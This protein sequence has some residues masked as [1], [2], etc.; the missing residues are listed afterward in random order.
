MPAR[1]ASIGA[2]A[3]LGLAV[4]TAGAAHASNG[5]A[6]ANEGAT[7]THKGATAAHRLTHACRAAAGPAG[8]QLVTETFTGATAPEFT[9]YNEACLTG[10]PEGAPPHG[11]HGL[12]GCEHS[13][14]GPVPPL[15]AAPHGYLR[16]TDAGND[17][18]AAVLYNHALPS[19]AGFDVTFDAWQYGSTTPIA[20]AD[21]ISFFL[22]DGEASLTVPGQFGGSLG[23]AQKQSHLPG[24]GVTPIEPGVNDGYLGVGLDALGNYFADNEQRGNGCA[25][26]SPAGPALASNVSYKERGPNMVI[27]RGPGNGTEGYCYITATTQFAHSRPSSLPVA[28]GPAGEPAGLAD[29]VHAAGHAGKRR[30]AAG[31]VRPAVQ[32]PGDPGA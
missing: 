32:R 30:G 19:S 18:T 17:R 16:L 22:T 27:L 2:A 29:G 11:D 9:G 10:A 20:A 1:G 6:T 7:A 21:G 4:L 14:L 13:D 25:T 8:S 24:G 12:G 3:A 5:T 26:H 28:I 31:V 23:Y 15:D